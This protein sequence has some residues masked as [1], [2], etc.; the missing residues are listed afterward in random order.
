MRVSWGGI[1]LEVP[2]R[3]AKKLLEKSN[4]AKAARERK[5]LAIQAIIDKR[6][7]AAAPGVYAKIHAENFDSWYES[8]TGGKWLRAIEIE[9]SHA[10]AEIERVEYIEKHP[11]EARRNALEYRHGCDLSK[12]SGSERRR[13][14]M[15]LATPV[16]CDRDAIL[17]I[18]IT[19]KIKTM[20]TGIVHHVD[21]VIPLQGK[22]VCGFHVHTNLRIIT[23]KENFSKNNR[24]APE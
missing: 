4:R 6:L 18:Y 16:W 21:H 2:D 20:L 1:N 22:Y 13:M 23:A 17:D 10:E 24:Y 15:S 11:H 5:K 12:L 3:E 7:L 19:C 9:P 14:Y 8:V